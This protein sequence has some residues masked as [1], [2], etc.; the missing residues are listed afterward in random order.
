MTSSPSMSCVLC[1]T[2]IETMNEFHPDG[3]LHFRAYGHYGTTVFD[4]M[5]G[6]SLDICICDKCLLV[7]RNNIYGTGRHHLDENCK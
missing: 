1:K 6:T 5:D 2:H 7:H 4:P 3:G